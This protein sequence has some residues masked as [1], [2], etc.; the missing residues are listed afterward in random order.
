M[1]ISLNLYVKRPTCINLAII[2]LVLS[3]KQVNTP[4]NLK[5]TPNLMPKYKFLKFQI[6]VNTICQVVRICFGPS[7]PSFNFP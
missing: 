5:S 6:C 2:N 7:S 4:C 1:F 3:E